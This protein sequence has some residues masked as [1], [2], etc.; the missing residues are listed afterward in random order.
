MTKKYNLK[1]YCFSV[2]ST[3]RKNL[4]LPNIKWDVYLTEVFFEGARKHTIIVHDAEHTNGKYFT[5]NLSEIM[6]NYL[7]VRFFD[8]NDRDKNDDDNS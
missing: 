6:E 5:F 2:E 4:G 8:W 3:R 7:T 1:D